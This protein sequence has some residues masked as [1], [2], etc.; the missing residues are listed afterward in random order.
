MFTGMV[1]CEGQR[2]GILPS[3]WHGRRKGHMPVRE[4]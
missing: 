4:M 3:G 2:G 1:P